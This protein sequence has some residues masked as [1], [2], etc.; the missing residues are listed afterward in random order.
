MEKALLRNDQHVI[1]KTV[2][3][4]ATRYSLM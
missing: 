3:T 2:A 1:A 4:V